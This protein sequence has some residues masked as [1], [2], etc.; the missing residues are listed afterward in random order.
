MTMPDRTIVRPALPFLLLFLSVTLIPASACRPARAG[1]LEP[2]AVDI[3]LLEQEIVAKLS[4][5]VEIQPG[6]KLSARST[7]EDKNRARAYL[8]DVWKGLGLAVQT[9][10]YS[11]EGRNIFAAVGPA[12]P[13]A[14]T[15]VF[16]AHYDSARNTPGANDNAT[17]TALVTAAAA[18]LSRLSPLGRRLVFVLFDEEERGLRGSRA[19]QRHGGSRRQG[20]FRH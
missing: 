19:D 13:G 10:D 9:Q 16:G 4:G 6:L 5:Q 3:G 2:P 18:R 15:L 12:D 7:L 8:I 17:G 20:R 1:A 14:E 11:A